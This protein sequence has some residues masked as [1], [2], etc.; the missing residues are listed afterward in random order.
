MQI[1]LGGSCQRRGR[2]RLVTVAV[3]PHVPEQRSRARFHALPEP[4]GASPTSREELRHAPGGAAVAAPQNRGV[5]VRGHPADIP[6]GRSRPF[7]D[8]GI[9]SLLAR[10]AADCASIGR[11]CARGHRNRHGLRRGGDR[12]EDA[13]DDVREAVREGIGD[14]SRAGHGTP[15]SGGRNRTHPF[16]SNVRI[17]RRFGLLA[18]VD[19]RHFV[20]ACTHSGSTTRDP[21]V[22]RRTSS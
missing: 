13:V 11:A 15:H 2:N 9:R 12:T 16:L 21:C 10:S 3:G 4:D 18:R 19:F 8:A 14:G 20:H 5:S 7:A 1:W 22:R 6:R 17:S